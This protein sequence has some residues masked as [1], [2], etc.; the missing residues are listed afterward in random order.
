MTASNRDVRS[1]PESGHVQRT[2]A[3]PLSA[4]SGH[5][6]VKNRCPSGLLLEVDRKLELCRLF[7]W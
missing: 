2:H 7:N 1:Y 6:Q 5:R 4:N 3:C